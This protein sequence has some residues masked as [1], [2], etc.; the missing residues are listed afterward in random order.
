MTNKPKLELIDGK[1]YRDGVLEP[2]EFGNWEQIAVMKE[3]QKQ[4]E[5]KEKKPKNKKSI[6][7]ES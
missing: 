7:K 5:L 3:A 1:F 4:A 6:N 2:I